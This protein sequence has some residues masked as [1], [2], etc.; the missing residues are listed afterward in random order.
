MDSQQSA[1]TPNEAPPSASDKLK[2]INQEK[3]THRQMTD[4]VLEF[5]GSLTELAQSGELVVFAGVVST[6]EKSGTFSFAQ[7]GG[8]RLTAIGGLEMAKAALMK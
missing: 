2:E 4:E 5:L 6:S 3:V 8:V 1:P 7:E